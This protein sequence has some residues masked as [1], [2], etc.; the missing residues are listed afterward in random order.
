MLY[1]LLRW[2][3]SVALRW[4]YRDIRVVGAERIPREGAV[5]FAV[6]HPNALVDALV[7][8]CVVP[9]RLRM[10]GKA[11]LFENPLLAALL[12]AAGVVPLRRVSDERKRIADGLF[13]DTGALPARNAESFRALGDVLASGGAMLIFPEGKSHSEPSIARLKTGVARIAI[14]ARDLRDVQDLRIVPLGLVFERKEEPRTRVLVQVGEPIPVRGFRWAPPAA[15]E[16]DALTARVDRGLRDV[17]LNFESPAHAERVLAVA[18]V[19]S[20]VADEPRELGDAEPAFTTVLDTVRRI[21]AARVSMEAAPAGAPPGARVDAFLERL[22]R[23]QLDLHDRHIMVSDVRIDIDVKSGAQF[24][25][26]EG[27]IDRKSVV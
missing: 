23:F 2:I 26:R 27:A 17:T 20:A 18:D 19:I 11:T 10:T 22:D 15:S 4:Y 8:G 25:M 16:V 3:A 1:W 5:I 13:P 21:E 14:E 9:R 24:A 12:S 7:A 6:N